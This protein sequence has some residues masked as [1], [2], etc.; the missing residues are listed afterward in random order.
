MTFLPSL[1]LAACPKEV[2]NEKPNEK[3]SS[4]PLGRTLNLSGQVFTIESQTGSALPGFALPDIK[5]E[6]FSG[7]L[8]VSAG[9]ISGTGEIKNGLLNITVPEPKAGDLTPFANTL[10]GLVYQGMASII[11]GD[12]NIKPADTKGAL[13]A[14]EITGSETHNSLAKTDF[15][16]STTE[17]LSKGTMT[18][19][20]EMTSY[21]YVDRNTTVTATGKTTDMSGLLSLVTEIPVNSLNV[22]GS[23][24]NMS[25]NTGWNAVY[26]K[27]TAVLSIISGKVDVTIGVSAANPNSLK[28]TLDPL[29]VFEE[30]AGE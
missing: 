1:V 5:Y 18:I 13:L 23:R 4:A 11:Y 27:T 30:F 6:Q 17:L 19:I 9:G 29:K 24:I 12:I 21:L 20:S 22:T 7:N 28:W 3:P 2:A 26:I 14:L 8:G 25:L 15:K 16:I 10:Q